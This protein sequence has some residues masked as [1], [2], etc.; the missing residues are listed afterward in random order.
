MPTTA[1]MSAVVSVYVPEQAGE[2][3]PLVLLCMAEV[4]MAVVYLELVVCS[5]FFELYRYRPTSL[6]N[7]GRLRILVQMLSVYTV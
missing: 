2:A 6:D 1:V 4:V 5:A 7:T 3:V